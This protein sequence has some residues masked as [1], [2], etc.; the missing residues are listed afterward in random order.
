MDSSGFVLSR[1]CR[2]TCFSQALRFS[3]FAFC[4]YAKTVHLWSSRWFTLEM[5]RIYGES[6]ITKG[7]KFADGTSFTVFSTKDDCGI[8][9]G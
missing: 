9:M 1:Q 6:S 4:G 7:L 3:F 5:R 8:S 2:K